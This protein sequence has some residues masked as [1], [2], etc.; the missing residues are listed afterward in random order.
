MPVYDPR[1][2]DNEDGVR[3]GTDYYMMVLTPHT[4]CSFALG[5]IKRDTADWVVNLPGGIELICPHGKELSIDVDG[6]V[7]VE[8]K[9]VSISRIIRKNILKSV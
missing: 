7:R 1:M 9:I 2:I 5:D 4:G 6:I 8:G 3:E